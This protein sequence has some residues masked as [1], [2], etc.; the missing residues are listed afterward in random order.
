MAISKV[1][2]SDNDTINTVEVADTNA[3]TVVTVG[4]QGPEGPN[5]ILGASV[6]N[7]YPVGSTDNG[8]GLIY[9]HANTRWLASTNSLANSL[10][11]K[12]P[13]LTF[14]SGQTVSSILD[15]DNMGSDSNT[16]LATQQSIKAYVNSQI[17]GVDLDF[18]GE[19]N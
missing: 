1:T 13:N 14:N 19:L 4:T 16:A 2:V 5:T 6:A 17:A 7:A 3:I 12:I 15:E 8:A 10:N 9:D 11:F 18:Q